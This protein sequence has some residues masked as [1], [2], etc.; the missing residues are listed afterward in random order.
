MTTFS[1][2]TVRIVAGA[3]CPKLVT[4]RAETDGADA[5]SMPL[6]VMRRPAWIARRC[7]SISV[8]SYVLCSRAALLQGSAPLG[9][10]HILLCVLFKQE[11]PSYKVPNRLLDG[12]HISIVGL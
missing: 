7:R 12:L 1:M 6:A 2:S 11:Y 5:A 4:L 9:C 10:A 3:V 8:A